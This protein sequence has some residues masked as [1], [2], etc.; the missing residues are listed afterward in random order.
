VN[1]L[2]EHLQRQIARGR[3]PP[4]HPFELGAPDET[5]RVDLP[6]PGADVS[7]ADGQ[8]QS[9]LACPQGLGLT[10]L[11]NG[12]CRRR[13]GQL[14]QLPVPFIRAASRAEVESERAEHAPLL[15]EDGRRPA[16]TQPVSQRDVTVIVPER[17]GRNVLHEHRLAA[18]GRRAA[19]AGARSD[20]LA[21]DSTGERRRKARSRSVVHM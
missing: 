16:G 5:I 8:T 9:F 15:V 17:V 3:R 19:R 11:D 20:A 13:R 4:E 6:F 18:E 7:A 14:D 10:I 12:D 21:V 2:H 1:S